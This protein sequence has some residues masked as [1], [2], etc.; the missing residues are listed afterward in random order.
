MGDQQQE[1]VAQ[2]LFQQ[3]YCQKTMMRG[4]ST[5]MLFHIEYGT[6]IV[7]KDWYAYTLS[8]WTKD[9]LKLQDIYETICPAQVTGC[10]PSERPWL[11]TV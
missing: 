10:A 3:N 9:S 8:Q 5:T 1:D 2:Q 6:V 7:G 11:L 4:G